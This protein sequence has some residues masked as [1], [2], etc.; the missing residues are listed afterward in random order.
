MDHQKFGN[1]ISGE[2]RQIDLG[3]TGKNVM[4]QMCLFEQKISHE[5]QNENNFE[6]PN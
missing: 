5:K 6:L 3:N 1:N 4:F 2:V